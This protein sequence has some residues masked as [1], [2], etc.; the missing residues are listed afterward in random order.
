MHGS[1]CFGLRQA[2]LLVGG[3]KTGSWQEW[4]D[5]A[6]PVAERLFSDHVRELS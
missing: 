4:Y 2:V 5:E 1:N 3:D 6:I